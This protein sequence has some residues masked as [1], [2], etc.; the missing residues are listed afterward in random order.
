MKQYF[1]MKITL[2]LLLIFNKQEINKSLK[3]T[4]NNFFSFFSFFFNPD[5]KPHIAKYGFG[6]SVFFNI[7]KEELKFDSKEVGTN[8]S[9]SQ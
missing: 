3:K 7:T 8:Q 4:E 2:V 1:N 5:H 9:I 6:P